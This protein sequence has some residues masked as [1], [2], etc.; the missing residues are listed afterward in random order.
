MLALRFGWRV[1]V[2]LAAPA[3]SECRWRWSAPRGSLP[4]GPGHWPQFSSRQLDYEHRR[5]RPWRHCYH[6]L[7]FVHHQ[8]QHIVPNVFGPNAH[9]VGVVQ[10]RVA[11]EQEQA[12]SIVKLAA[13]LPKGV[14]PCQN[15]VKKRVK[16][17]LA[18]IC[19]I[20]RT[21][22]SNFVGSIYYPFLLPG[23][24]E[25]ICPRPLLLESPFPQLVY[26]YDKILLFA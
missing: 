10:A 3:P 24:R 23:G 16:S 12:P 25:Y 14:I 26:S 15:A 21:G 19:P 6:I 17:K 5:F 4:P 7:R 8:S 13:D 9:E 1:P 20:I 22:E 18:E 11:T 2:A